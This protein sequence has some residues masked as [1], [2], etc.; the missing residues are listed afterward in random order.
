MHLD[1]HLGRSLS[2]SEVV[3]QQD[4][5]TLFCDGDC[6]ALSGFQVISLNLA[7][8]G[9]DAFVREIRQ[10]GR[11][12]TR[13]EFV[14]DRLWHEQCVERPEQFERVDFGEVY[15]RARV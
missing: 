14:V 7:F 12:T 3:R 10:S 13:L 8:V 4:D 5:P 1:A 2:S 11:N 15:E 6:G 9:V